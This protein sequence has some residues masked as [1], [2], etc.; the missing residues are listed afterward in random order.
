MSLDP[1][2]TPPAA[3]AV[4]VDAYQNLAVNLLH[5]GSWLRAHQLH[6]LKP[7]GITPEQYNILRILRGQHPEPATVKRIRARMIDR[8]SN[9]SRLVEKL[10]VKGLVDRC[11]C[12]DDRRAVDIL[13]T[14][15]GLAVLE[16]LDATLPRLL[17]T[18]QTLSVEEATQLMALLDK[19]RG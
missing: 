11:I 18:F 19:L 14:D 4:S 16:A 15:D 1:P 2:L 17:K 12:P 9:V 13:I 5:T 6:W 8:M 10:R 3:P 7:Y